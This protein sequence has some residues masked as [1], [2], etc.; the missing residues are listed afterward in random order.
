[1]L[2][3]ASSSLIV[4]APLR[5]LSRPAHAPYNYCVL[6]IKRVDSG[7]FK[8]T[9]VFPGG[10]QEPADLQLS[11]SLGDP[12]AVG[13]SRLCALRETYEETGLLLAK[14]ASTAAAIAANASGQSFAS[15]CASNRGLQMHEA[16]LIGRWVTPRAAK[17]RFDTRFFL[18]SI[19]D[20]DAHLLDQLRSVRAQATEVVQMDWLRPDEALQANGRRQIAMPVP[21]LYI[22]NELSRV[23]RWQDLHR[24]GSVGDGFEAILCPRSDGKVVALLPGDRAYT[25]DAAVADAELFGEHDASSLHRLVLERAEPGGFYAIKLLRSAAAATPQKSGHK[26]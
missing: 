8:S 25:H 4:T 15:L 21:Q 17:R 9:H 18:S 11:T 10:V 24:I 22:L 19:S 13:G 2:P 1:M 14:P 5:Q 3:R 26:L 20:Q 7:T 12:T 23:H 16:R 6:M